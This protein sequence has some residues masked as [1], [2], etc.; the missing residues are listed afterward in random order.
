LYHSEKFGGP[1]EKIKEACV[2]HSNIHKIGNFPIAIKKV[3]LQVVLPSETSTE[4]VRFKFCTTAQIFAI[5]TEM[6]KN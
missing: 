5:R 6:I 1:G 4:G 3:R 2:E